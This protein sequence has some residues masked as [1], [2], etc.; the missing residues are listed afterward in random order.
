MAIGDVYSLV[1]DATLSAQQVLNV[2]HYQVGAEAGGPSSATELSDEFQA[3]VLPEIADTLS[4][5]WDATRLTITNIGTPADFVDLALSPPVEGTRT[6]ENI[7]S[8]VTWSFRLN[9]VNPGQRVGWKRFSGLSETDVFGSTAQ[10]GVLA[11]LTACAAAL[12]LS[13]VGSNASY[14]PS[15]VSRPIILGITPTALYNFGSAS[16]AG[17]GSQVSRKKPF[18]I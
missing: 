15:V 1:L 12:G 17:V 3:S 11:A 18:T 14:L 8:V 4:A 13:L 5:H 16:F 9:R 10:S 7:N 2:F 6:G